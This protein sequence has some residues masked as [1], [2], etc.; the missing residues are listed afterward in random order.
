MSTPAISNPASKPESKSAK[1]KKAKADAAAKGADVPL[2]SPG[3]PD[4]GSGHTPTEP[5]ANGV[6]G[7][8]ESNHMKELQK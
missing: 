4:A 3:D 6:D 5:S 8:Y 7:Q 1:K 2:A